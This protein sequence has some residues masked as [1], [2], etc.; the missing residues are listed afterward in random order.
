MDAVSLLL[1]TP[2]VTHEFGSCRCITNPAVRTVRV[3]S[4]VRHGCLGAR[5][6]GAKAQVEGVPPGVMEAGPLAV[7]PASVAGDQ[8]RP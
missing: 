4:G 3:L 5:A 6:A 8:R 1:H 2:A 7:A